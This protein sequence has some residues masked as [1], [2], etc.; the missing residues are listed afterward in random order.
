MV[1]STA[2]AVTACGQTKARLQARPQGTATPVAGLHSLG[3]RRSRDARFYVPKGLDAK[4][5]PLLMYL[6]GAGGSEEQ[7]I[8]RL[9]EFADS[10]GFL[11]LSP[12]SENQTW[13]AIRDGYGR[14]V[15]GIDSGLGKVFE[16]CSIDPKR[17]GVCGFS[18]GASY[19]LGL[20]L[21]NGDLFTHV[22]AFSPGFVP[23]PFEPSGKPRVF[24]SHG[25]KDE[26]LPIDTCSRQIVP[27]LK[28]FY[29]VTYREF[30]GPHRVPREINE[31]ALRWFLASPAARFGELR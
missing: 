18:D 23:A 3:I 24:I 4:P 2:L 26:V 12:A 22:M 6:H 30:E 31:E 15:R 25:T 16:Q 28:R 10:L 21:A 13:D 14:D 20:G 19:A 27:R 17:V 5:A 1:L 29:D 11:L 8:K 7:G 9:S